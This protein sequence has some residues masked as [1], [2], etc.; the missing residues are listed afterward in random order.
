MKTRSL[1]HTLRAALVL[2]VI[3]ALAYA[4]Q[5]D[6]MSITTHMTI[7]GA[8][9]MTPHAM[10]M[11]RCVAPGAMTQ[12]QTYAR[13]QNN[14]TVSDVKRSANSVSAHLVCPQL[15]ADIDM[16]MSGSSTHGT[17]HMVTNAGGSPMT[18]DQT[19]DAKR[20]GSCDYHAQ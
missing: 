14:C 12:P 19:F 18:M 2:A 9:G 6:L 20:I 1:A 15:T 11:Q 17:M 16:H 4:S 7:S 5:G 8:P 13:H 3:P 10:T